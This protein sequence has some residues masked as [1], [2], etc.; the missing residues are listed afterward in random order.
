M[1]RHTKKDIELHKPVFAMTRTDL[2]QNET[3]AYDTL[4]TAVQMNL[5]TTSMKGKTSGA[6]DSILNSRQTKHAQAALRNIRLACSGGTSIVPTISTKFWNETIDLM[7][8]THK[9]D[10]RKISKVEK[11]LTRMT[12]E[13][14]SVC[15]CCGIELQTLFLLP[16]ACQ[17]CTECM[18]PST[19]QCVSCKKEFDIDDFQ[20]LQPGLDYTWKWNITE[21]QKQR[22]E[23]Q[24]M[25]QSIR[26]SLITGQERRP[27][28]WQ[29]NN[30]GH[31]ADHGEN[32]NDQGAPRNRLQ[33]Q[34]RRRRNEPH[35]CIYPDIYGDGRC[36][37][38]FETHPCNFMQR[39]KCD[40]CHNVAEECPKEES[41]AFYII[42]KL[43]NLW[44]LYQHR[45][46]DIVTGKEKR[47]LKVLIFTQF[48]QVSNLVG[49]R[50]I[51]RFGTACIAEY[52]GTT[53][54]AE[55]ERFRSVTDCFCM[56]LNR[57]GS[58]GL[59]LSFVTHIFFLDEILGE[60][61]STTY[62]VRLSLS[63]STPIDK[64]HFGVLDKSLESQVVSRAY[65]M[66]ATENVFVE[67]LVSR[68][69]IEEL[70]VLMNKREEKK[71]DLLYANSKD[72]EKFESEYY[73]SKCLVPREDEN[74]VD[75]NAKV[76]YIL[77]NM[78]LIRPNHMTYKKRRNNLIHSK[79]GKKR[80]RFADDTAK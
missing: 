25:E 66:G 60:L 48:Q 50:L 26:E 75:P 40:I 34:R 68:H 62:V 44:S 27:N 32:N 33:Q 46:I 71:H 56:L 72:M 17:I 69:T 74:K 3:K 31:N 67:Q 1:V 38:C 5:I 52:W 55:L 47:P 59:N 18:N 8:I 21:A 15:G 43:L 65:R 35:V 41:K 42:E 29:D 37:I 4:V 2:S 53:R 16:C 80:I 6:Q 23:T 51:R 28:L 39:H 49:D 57:D 7:R 63:S 9:V 77:S 13:E 70:I 22:E 64:F 76:R 45:G 14:L 11:F 78:K 61:C 24:N 73:D 36:K 20:R 58:H 54:N 79:R 10:E 19:N 30:A 12:T